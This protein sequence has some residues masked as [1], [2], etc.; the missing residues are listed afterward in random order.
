MTE[1]EMLEQQLRTGNVPVLRLKVKENQVFTLT[2]RTLLAA[3]AKNPKH[4]HAKIYR[5]VAEGIPPDEELNVDRIDLEALL[6]NKTVEVEYDQHMEFV[7]GQNQLVTTER[8]VFKGGTDAKD[9]GATSPAA[10][11]S[12]DN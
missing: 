11:A 7:D 3:C 12:P 10:V 4:P 2:A 6:E 1:L 8:K 9:A 5:S